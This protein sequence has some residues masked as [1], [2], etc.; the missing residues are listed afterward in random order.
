M[1]IKEESDSF[2]EKIDSLRQQIFDSN[3]KLENLELTKLNSN[4]FTDNCDRVDKLLVKLDDI[5][6]N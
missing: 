5:A 4:K 1:G 2:I 3:S 6:V